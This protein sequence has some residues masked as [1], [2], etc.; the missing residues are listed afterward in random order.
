[1]MAVIKNYDEL[2]EVFRWRID[3]LTTKYKIIFNT[4]AE[5]IKEERE[6][7]KITRCTSLT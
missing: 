7:D 6:E 3:S 2:R 4:R 5:H 1:M